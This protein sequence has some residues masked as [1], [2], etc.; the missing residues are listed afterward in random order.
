[1][2]EQELLKKF[3]DDR[4]Q[5]VIAASDGEEEGEFRLDQ[6]TYMAADYL[7]DAGEV[8][9]INICYYKSRGLQ[10]NGYS[11]SQDEDC[12]DLFITIFNQQSP[13]LNVGKVQCETAFKQAESCLKKGFE[14]FHT[15]L[16]EASESY[17]VFQRIHELRKQVTRCRIYLLTDGI[18]KHESFDAEDIGDVTVSLN[19][20]DI[21]RIY[22][23]ASSGKK[24]EPIEID[25]EEDFG[26]AIPCLSLMDPDSD[27]KGY[28]AVIPGAVLAGIYERFGPRLLERNVR[29]FLQARGKVNKGIRKTIIE[30]PH[31]FF[32]YNNGITATA[33][34]IEFKQEENGSQAIKKIKNLQIVNGGQTTASLFHT[35]KKDKAEIDGIYVQTKLSVIPATHLEEIVPLISRYANSQNKVNEADFY[36]ND[37][38]HVKIEELSR[39]VW[40][41]STDGTSRQTKWFY[42]RARGQY[43]DAKAR[44]GTPARKRQFESMYP[45]RQKFTK[46]DLA[47]YENTWMQLPH[48]VSLGAQKNFSDF[49]IRLREK[50]RVDSDQSFYEHLIAKAILFK[51]TEKIVSEQDY[52]GYRANIV[53][54]SLAWLSHHTSQRIDLGAIWKEQSLL[55]VLQET[56]RSISVFV[57][58]IITNPPSQKNVT[59]WCK[60]KE[61]WGKIKNEKF[62]ID[63]GFESELIDIGYSPT[64]SPDRG[65]EGPNEE[66]KKLID[67]IRKVPADRWKK[68]AKWAKETNNLKPWQRGLAFSIGRLCSQSNPVSPR[69][70]VQGMKLLEE[71]IRLG[72]KL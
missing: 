55:P 67:E 22:R 20:W 50:G 51:K 64:V 35:V 40:A 48:I 58:E 23:F 30:E 24:F 57:Q 68:I 45:S 49:S 26:K 27:Y 17:D 71:A 12:I 36:A 65:I 47:K 25:F 37:P 53:T 34:N 69:Q 9:D 15:S 63:R 39:I 33:D 72:F 11:V 52:G 16:E 56:I 62:K 41:P 2:N 59:E 31:R 43:L 29:S 60:K 4:L 38:F 13:P 6:F 44:E 61:C 54:Y 5:E 21:E 19:V 70:A 10:M 28:L 46:T 18:V 3:S 7:I 14:G 66:E 8:D 42:E 32:A 1:M